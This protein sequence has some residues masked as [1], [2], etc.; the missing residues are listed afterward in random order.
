MSANDPKRTFD[1]IRDLKAETSWLVDI[2]LAV[3][4]GASL[5][6]LYDHGEVVNGATIRT[7]SASVCDWMKPTPS[8]SRGG[9]TAGRTNPPP[10]AG[11]AR[12]E[13]AEEAHPTSPTCVRAASKNRQ[14]LADFGQ[15]QFFCRLL[16]A[17]RTQVGDVG[18]SCEGESPI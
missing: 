17:A 7:R 14:P 15:G 11:S 6:W 2:A 13:K 4:D 8:A 1:G 12:G 9:S 10:S 16:E 5:A 18:W 3:E